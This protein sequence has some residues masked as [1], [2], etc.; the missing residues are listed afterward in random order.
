[1]KGR[2]FLAL[3]LAMTML[4]QIVTGL[5]PSRSD[6]AAMRAVRVMEAQS[7]E[8]SA[9]ESIP[10]GGSEISGRE[11]PLVIDSAG[12]EE[13]A[14]SEE[15]AT[16]EKESSSSEQPSN[17]EQTA[18]E[19]APEAGQ[20]SEAALPQKENSPETPKTGPETMPEILNPTLQPLQYIEYK[21]GSFSYETALALTWKL[22]K[23]V[24]A[25]SEAS[26]VLPEELAL[27][28]TTDLAQEK[29][30]L[31][32]IKDSA[33]HVL[34]RVF[35]KYNASQCTLIFQ[36]TEE[37]A[38]LAQKE[39]TGLEGQS[40]IGQ[41]IALK[42]VAKADDS[43]VSE[44]GWNRP[45]YRGLS[46]KA[47]THKAQAED[48]ENQKVVVF[49]ILARGEKKAVSVSLPVHQSQS[50]NE[51]N[52]IASLY[53]CM[54]VLDAA[55]Q[56]S[57]ELTGLLAI[58]QKADVKSAEESTEEAGA[59]SFAPKRLHI[60]FPGVQEA[61]S[62]SLY[63]VQNGQKTKIYPAEGADFITTEPGGFVL[64]VKTLH[65][66]LTETQNS[67]ASE[68]E[69]HL[70]FEC[71]VRQAQES[72][73]LL[74]QA[75]LIG[76]AE[77]E[78]GKATSAAEEPLVGIG[79][80]YRVSQG[81]AST[82]SAE[83]SPYI[84]EQKTIQI[85]AATVAEKDVPLLFPA[86]FV[87]EKKEDPENLQLAPEKQPQA[88]KAPTGIPSGNDPLKPGSHGS[89]R[90]QF[91][92]EIEYHTHQYIAKQSGNQWS[93]D[94]ANDRVVWDI[95]LETGALR[96]DS[97]NF[98]SLSYSL[99]A[100]KNQGL[101]DFTIS[102]A[103]TK[104]G[105][106]PAGQ[107]TA[108]SGDANMAL[109]SETQNK[110]NIGDRRWIRVS[111]KFDPETKTMPA[112]RN[113]T[114]EVYANPQSGRYTLGLR[115]TPDVNYVWAMRQAFIEAYEKLSK[116]PLVITWL[117]G[118][119]ATQIFEKGFNL[120][121]ARFTSEVTVADFEYESRF[122]FDKTRT[123]TGKFQ[124]TSANNNQTN[125]EVI[126]L[127][128][129]K[130]EAD[131][132]IQEAAF[133]KAG[134]LTP[135][136]NAGRLQ[137][138]TAYIPKTAGGYD[139]VPAPTD[140][141]QLR[142]WL[143]THQIPGTILVYRFVADSDTPYEE[144][145]ITINF[146]EKWDD[147]MG[148]TGGRQQA[149][150][151]EYTDAEK[152]GEYYVLPATISDRAESHPN[153]SYQATTMQIDKTGELAY[154][155][156]LAKT[157]H[158][159]QLGRLGLTQNE[160]HSDEILINA[161]DGGQEKAPGVLTLMKKIFFYT[162]RL[163]KEYQAQYGKKMNTTFYYSLVQDLIWYY[164]QTPN[165]LADLYSRKN[166]SYSKNGQGKNH[167]AP[168]F[169]APYDA[170]VEDSAVTTAGHYTEKY[171]TENQRTAID[172]YDAT[173]WLEDS[174]IKQ[175]NNGTD[176][177]QDKEDS[178]RVRLYTHKEMA[179]SQTL[180]TGDVPVPV[181]FAK[182]DQDGKGLAG[183][184]FAIYDDT[185][186]L[187]KAWTSR[188]ADA[189]DNV[190]KDAIYLRPG[191]YVLKE[192]KAPD[193]RQSIGEMPFEIDFNQ[194][195]H[196]VTAQPDFGLLVDRKVID[197]ETYSLRINGADIPYAKDGSAPLV[198]YQDMGLTVKNLFDNTAELQFAKTGIDGRVIDGAVFRLVS[199]DGNAG[200]E[201]TYDKRSEGEKGVFKFVG[202]TEQ[203]G[204]YT[205]TEITAPAGYEMPTPNT[206]Q[207]QVTKGTDPNAKLQAKIVGI[208]SSA[209]QMQEIPNEPK[210]TEMKFRKVDE[211]DPSKGLEGAV[212][213]LVQTKGG[214]YS[215]QATSAKYIDVQDND[216]LGY[217]TFSD[218]TIG[219]YTLQELSAPNGYHQNPTTW[220]VVVS[221]EAGVLVTKIYRKEA[222]GESEVTLDAVTKSY[223]IGN[224]VETTSIKLRKYK[225]EKNPLELFT[226]ADLENGKGGKPVQFKLYET[227]YYGN[228]L[229]NAQERI[230]ALKE[231]AQGPYF[232][233]DNL[234]SGGYY[235]L[236]EINS[237]QNYG[238][239]PGANPSDPN[240]PNLPKLVW[241][242]KV[243]TDAQT[244]QLKVLV[245]HPDNA[246]VLDPDNQLNGIK[247][248]PDNE[249]KGRLV[250]RKI[251]NSIPK[252][253]ET[254]HT[255]GIR[256]AHIR[257]YELDEVGVKK[258]KRRVN[259]GGFPIYQERLSADGTAD[260]LGWA[261]FEN[262][263]PGTYELVEHMSPAGYKKSEN[264][265][266]VTVEAGGLTSW[267]QITG[268]MK[269][270]ETSKIC[271]LSAGAPNLGPQ[272]VELI[273][274]ADTPLGG[275]V[276]NHK[277]THQKV[278][279]TTEE[280]Y[281]ITA[282]MT[283]NT[284]TA[285]EPKTYRII[286]GLDRQST[287]GNIAQNNA[288][289]DARIKQ[290][291]QDLKTEAAKSKDNIELALLN[292]GFSDSENGAHVS[293]ALQ[294]T[295]A[296][297]FT[298]LD[299]NTDMNT[300]YNA[301]A[302]RRT[303]LGGTN[304]R[305]MGGPELVDN[306][307]VANFGTVSGVQKN[308]FVH[309]DNSILKFPDPDKDSDYVGI[310][311]FNTSLCGLQNQG[312][313]VWYLHFEADT[314]KICKDL[315][316]YIAPGGNITPLQ[317]DQ[318]LRQVYNSKTSDPSKFFQTSDDVDAFLQR[319]IDLIP[320][321]PNQN[322]Q[323]ENGTYTV[324][325]K[326]GFVLDGTPK[327][328]PATYATKLTVSPDHKSFTVEGLTLPAEETFQIQYTLQRDATVL[329]DGYHEMYAA[330]LAPKPGDSAISIKGVQ[331]HPAPTTG[332]GAI[333]IFNT[334]EDLSRIPL[335]VTKVDKYGRVKS[336]A[337][338]RLRKDMT[339]LQAYAGYKD[340]KVPYDAIAA[341]TGEPGDYY[342]RELTP[343][344]YILEETKTPD[345]FVPPVDENGNPMHWI[346]KVTQFTDPKDG[347]V[348]LQ[349][350][351]PG[352]GSQFQPP[353]GI[354]SIPAA[355]YLVAVEDDGRTPPARPDA[356]Y[357]TIREAQITNYTKTT[358]IA[359]QKRDAEGTKTLAG[360]VF[361]L[362]GT[363][364]KRNEQ[365]P[366]T[367][368]IPQEPY[369]DENGNTTVTVTSDEDGVIFR[370]LPEGSYVI[371]EVKAPDG[372]QL[373]PG[374][375]NQWHVKVEWDPATGELVPKWE[376]DPNYGAYTVTLEGKIR[377]TNERA[378][379]NFKLEKVRA[380]D[381]APLYTSGFLLEK[382]DEQGNPLGDSV[383]QRKT[384]SNVYVFTDLSEG[385]YRLT[386]TV[387]P[388][389]YLKPEP[390]IFKVVADPNTG[391]LHFETELTPGRND[392][393][394]VFGNGSP[395]QSA[396][397]IT[398]GEVDTVRIK[399]YQSTEFEFQKVNQGSK[400][401]IGAEF[402]LIK[403]ETSRHDKLGYDATTRATFRY[404]DG[405]P[406]N[407]AAANQEAYAGN[408]YYRELK[409]D[410]Y[411]FRFDQLS[412]G[413]YELVEFTLPQGAKKPNLQ[414]GTGDFPKWTLKVE[415]GKTGLIV[416][417]IGSNIAPTQE[418]PYDVVSGDNF[419][420]DP[421]GGAGSTVIKPGALLYNRIITTTFRFS[422]AS[423]DDTQNYIAGAEFTM[424]KYDKS[425]L[426]TQGGSAQL[427]GPVL[428]PQ[429]Y[430][431][432]DGVTPSNQP[433]LQF[434]F[435]GLETGWYRLT[436]EKA[437]KG[438]LQPK[439]EGTDENWWT[440]V[441]VDG[442]LNITLPELK[443][444]HQQPG[445]ARKFHPYIR[446]ELPGD[447][448]GPM[449]IVNYLDMKLCIKKL[450]GDG[451]RINKDWTEAENVNKNRILSL[452]LKPAEGN[453]NAVPQ[454]LTDQ[455]KRIDLAT[456]TDK[457]F[458][459]DLPYPMDGEYIL[460]EEKAP[461][462]YLKSYDRYILS[463][464]RVEGT[465][466]LRA[467]QTTAGVDVLYKTQDL[468]KE[469][470]VL[471]EKKPN[472]EPTS[473]SL[474]LV[475]RKSEYP[476]SG[477]IGSR[478]F[479][480]AGTAMSLAALLGW[481]YKRRRRK[482]E[483]GLLC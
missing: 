259:A 48:R 382:I 307:R 37:G 325:V 108:F 168:W 396:G 237:P 463:I 268:G 481:E 309:I 13:Q 397:T 181:D 125:W 257:L 401:L 458:T 50:K 423:E 447:E 454:A 411:T 419:V 362:S 219:E 482:K 120:V 341:A 342:F 462:G 221:E 136:K 337:Q 12:S 93:I 15:Q 335:R 409:G 316:P 378:K 210:K 33:G 427:T 318:V 113:K 343:G 180:I 461:E 32:S 166:Y 154:C 226:K 371:K 182:V 283:G 418:K 434:T 238:V 466:Q 223:Q 81:T 432:E 58:P 415:R 403:T 36:V 406:E 278:P 90:E 368:V 394:I 27:S 460:T 439:R 422:K 98:N 200:Q 248:F 72:R 308:I 244:G 8:R 374:N 399:N 264:S 155:F 328:D 34:F 285:H 440:L 194:Q 255:I 274:P 272:D 169:E 40:L 281:T 66:Y 153:A 295:Q 185:G 276:Q 9:P 74:L 20:N 79:E 365:D 298:R 421:Q 266:L 381:N 367:G 291:L 214:N 477:G 433:M 193:G 442:E 184:K 183:A 215:R 16:T 86:D 107:G 205:L 426:G 165:S 173:Y 247:N 230:L 188:G 222:T 424:Q 137:S 87:V 78:E 135:D 358:D 208:A 26:V 44:G 410:R 192:Q 260:Q 241:N 256:R 70:Y 14:A 225:G 239:D 320:D 51:R 363:V 417:K 282:T 379:I 476:S 130:D 105:L 29:Q 302:P 402:R 112:A 18:S 17:V 334:D 189:N 357:Q 101:K 301:M 62:L 172:I 310:K 111:A 370:N 115:V 459:F 83:D 420:I 227:N 186:A 404:K 109:Y 119:D 104:E 150:L 170:R 457:G 127:L 174:L 446:F 430:F 356:P 416:K 38:A 435:T 198:T 245:S 148:T 89:T 3:T 478:P 144:N 469:P 110:A 360:A 385:R 122:Y 300:L 138:V 267:Q 400:P 209:G 97:I 129:M 262:L 441:Y 449:R 344:E 321:A 350:H 429:G 280:K 126:E 171:V 69:K 258:Y 55:G 80:T 376:Q 163:Q 143:S 10:D 332:N 475:N 84:T 175:I 250:A 228:K 164:S 47:E 391:A 349:V 159:S 456:Q 414:P 54:H 450:D 304:W 123:I 6:A 352:D 199:N 141:Q 473:Q 311:G 41:T 242:I 431:K 88:Q 393:E 236:E 177:T 131:P 361:E 118:A 405:N 24:K 348:K 464:N 383:E 305:K 364:V 369:K 324:Q 452:A 246:V 65:A 95:E 46:Y 151:R 128:R 158:Q 187:R 191:K 220:R 265:W 76:P 49:Q 327:L 133:T 73:E 443:K 11:A 152:Q 251:G 35:S 196:W 455:L 202:L 229:P 57:Q 25:G 395:S 323:V 287:F 61:P 149:G 217:F 67:Q 412:E 106:L 284:D 312:V 413:T 167:I 372:Y 102:T 103:D 279:G 2:R 445:N 290:F 336:Q 329:G 157:L 471:W 438:Y 314:V 465:V 240:A 203:A 146:Q 161:A 31:G 43:N 380:T 355:K 353:T 63:T 351:L 176:W 147:E 4:L 206:W 82:R 21:D 436:E 480:L 7:Q 319:I 96:S 366:S 322:K 197:G 59:A 132:S 425:P 313:D 52:Q 235:T 5:V 483:G 91:P 140:A 249:K 28:G 389:G 45:L 224:T 468:T 428:H 243:I 204:G 156:N 211:Q 448:T 195:F 306:L 213:E 22:S 315:D 467:I 299:A 359:F 453:T 252:D 99:Y 190:L 216:K 114:K 292:Y 273:D 19:L 346:I 331:Y 472:A 470:F 134:G 270:D 39:E 218:L 234:R 92:I 330:S 53:S 296:L 345:G 398:H 68:A 339:K 116:I 408:G 231:D 333:D 386:E 42:D 178:V 326:D 384:T 71:G 232:E 263:D 293:P 338:F 474:E 289:L 160:V 201:P 407:N 30:E 77:K 444:F 212:F 139:A 387:V 23:D 145:T 288:L 392:Y 162:D 347:K 277:T 233:L 269:Y 124:Q 286:V 64:D 437:P 94:Y 207:V 354:A 377:I 85:D 1:M 142:T 56:L 297:T 375:K 121:D 373:P 100:S 390:W 271:D 317:Q 254:Q 275:K 340:Y 117:Q 303:T 294:A 75:A 261:V 253:G 451:N 388:T 179:T 60:A 479:I